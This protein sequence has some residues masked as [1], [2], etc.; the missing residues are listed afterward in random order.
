MTT[1]THQTTT[2]DLPDDLYWAD[3]ASWQPVVQTAERT[4]TGALVLQTH[5]RIA[6]RPI[7]LQPDTDGAAWLTRAQLVTLMQW[8]SI[9]GCEMLLSHRGISYNV[10]WRH[11]DGE[12]IQAT[13]VVHY[14]DVQSGDFYTAT[15]RLME[16]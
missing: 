12:V 14:A 11:Q 9:P 6:G 1:L 16:I 3:E 10:V 5:A 8:A 15:L 13:P 2:L 7:T 4:I